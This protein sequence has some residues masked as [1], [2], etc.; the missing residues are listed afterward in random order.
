MESSLIWQIVTT[1]ASVAAVIGAIRYEVANLKETLRDL[2]EEN[3]E[4][5]KVQ[6]QHELDI[7]L[8]KGS[9]AN[10]CQYANEV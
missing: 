10:V 4:I 3:K 9:A 2:R 8:I 6:V 7:G 5:K 1:V